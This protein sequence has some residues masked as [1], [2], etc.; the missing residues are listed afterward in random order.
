MKIQFT[1]V[2]SSNLDAVAHYLDDLFIRFKNG[3]TYRYSDVPL[4]TFEELRDAPSVGKAFHALI[5]DKFE[6]ELCEPVDAE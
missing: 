3:K 5:R 6:C 2:E 4:E 1:P